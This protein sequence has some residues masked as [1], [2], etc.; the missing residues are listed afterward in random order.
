MKPL[1]NI[2]LVKLPEATYDEQVVQRG[3]DEAFYLLGYD[4][5]NFGSDDWN[6]LKGIVSPGDH[7]LLKPN[8]VMHENSNPDGGVLCLYTQPA[9]V[10]AVLKH[11]VRA[12]ES[13]GSITIADAPMQACD[14]E[15]LIKESGYGALVDRFQ[16]E[17]PTLQFSL[18]DLRGLKSVVKKGVYHYHKCEGAREVMVSLSEESSFWGL[19]EDR[20]RAMRVTNYDPDILNHYHTHTKHEYMV[21]QDVLDADVF[22]N[23]PKPKTHRKAGITCALK[24]VVG[25]VTRKECLPHHTNG[26]KTVESSSKGGDAYLYPSIFRRVEDWI[27]DHRN[28]LAQ[29]KRN[30]PAAWFFQ[31]CLR[32]NHFFARKFGV[33]KGYSEGSWYGNTT[34]SK[35][36]ADLNK[37]L[38]YA[39]KE[40][41]MS[42]ESKR[43]R[44]YLVVA[45]MVIAGDHDGPLSPTPNPIGL[46]GVGDN[47][48][49]F[50]EVIA[51]LYGAQMEYMHTINEARKT[52]DSKYPLVDINTEGRIC[53]NNPAWD[54]KTWKAISAKD[55]LHIVPVAGWEKA[56]AASKKK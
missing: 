12:C 56:F 46:I 30:I 25:I 17:N 23:I 35:T 36:I 51:T 1:K 50:D 43:V 21:A 41:V 40:G 53:S 22:I 16:R 28:W 49:Q 38:F 34:I 5:E 31:Q 55:K 15:I 20:I 3:I 48:V 54:G 6:P 24:N 37:I 18:R 19:P 52:I 44:R 39:G 26:H 2:A 11:V 47:P 7:V 14:W 45:D 29:T 27:L 4:A 9:V 32:V 13:K 42:G 8:M 10:A 33:E